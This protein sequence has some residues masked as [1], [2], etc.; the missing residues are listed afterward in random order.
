LTDYNNYVEFLLIKKI[1][2]FKGIFL[3]TYQ[4]KNDKIIIR[5]TVMSLKYSVFYD[6]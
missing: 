2:L 4:K 1:L 3:N 5:I 6:N